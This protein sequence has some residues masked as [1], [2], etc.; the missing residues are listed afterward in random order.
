MFWDA[1]AIVACLIPESR[2][3]EIAAWLRSDQ[4]TTLWWASPVEV[5]SALFRRQREQQLQR[6]P[7]NDALRRLEDLVEDADFVAPTLRVRDRAGRLLSSHPLRAADA[8]QL[9]AA[10]VWCEEAPR[11]ETFVSL[12]ERLRDAARREGFS[13]LPEAT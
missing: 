5:Q 13:L 6:A 10:L 12:D 4:A 8:L 2:S 1:S 11:G 9:A 7:L 3:G